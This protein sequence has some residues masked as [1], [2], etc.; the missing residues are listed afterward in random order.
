MTLSG[1][2]ALG[3]GLAV[4]MLMLTGHGW[5]AAALM[6]GGLGWSIWRIRQWQREQAER[7][8]LQ[9]SH[10]IADPTAKDPSQRS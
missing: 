5:A 4:G 3:A 6:V 2:I 9:W 8:R 1:M 10:T 7:E